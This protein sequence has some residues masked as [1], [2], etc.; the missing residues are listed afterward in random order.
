MDSSAQARVFFN[1][2]TA[3]GAFSTIQ[4]NIRKWGLLTPSIRVFSEQE[5]EE[6]LSKHAYIDILSDE[7]IL[8]NGKEIHPEDLRVALPDSFDP[9]STTIYINIPQEYSS[10]GIISELETLGFSHISV[11]RSLNF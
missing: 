9:D 6:H 3:K 10:D 1:D 4:R 5:F 7:S 11:N 8:F 2:E